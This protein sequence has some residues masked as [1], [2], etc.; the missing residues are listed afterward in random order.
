MMNGVRAPENETSLYND[1]FDKYSAN[2]FI[3]N[4]LE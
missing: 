4:S 3:N 1:Q 2:G